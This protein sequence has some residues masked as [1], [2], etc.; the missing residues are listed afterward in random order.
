MVFLRDHNTLILSA[1]MAE[2]DAEPI[3]NREQR[4]NAGIYCEVCKFWLSGSGQFTKHLTSIP[5]QTTQDL[6]E[7][8]MKLRIDAERFRKLAENHANIAMAILNQAREY[9]EQ[10][11][12]L[13]ANAEM[14]QKYTCEYFE[15]FEEHHDTPSSQNEYKKK[16]IEHKELAEMCMKES[17]LCKNKFKEHE[18]SGKSNFQLGLKN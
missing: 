16:L 1:T 3:C 13:E 8:V 11:K 18:Y 6:L 14:H 17:M 15:L 4:Q 7:Q 9:L 12:T 5:H 10:S 2:P